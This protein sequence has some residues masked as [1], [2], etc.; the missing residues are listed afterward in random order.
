[1]APCGPDTAVLGL[2]GRARGNNLD[3]TAYNK[4]K[5]KLVVLLLGSVET[6]GSPGPEEIKADSFSPSQCLGM[7]LSQVIHDSD[8]ANVVL[9]S[10]PRLLPAAPAARG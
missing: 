6:S 4:F 8:E 3:L 7:K 9:W 10:L 2:V 1:M 5:T